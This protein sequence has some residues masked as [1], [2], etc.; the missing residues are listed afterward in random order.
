MKSWLAMTVATA[1]LGMAGTAGA[2]KLTLREVSMR[3]FSG[4]INDE[5]DHPVL[6]IDD[7]KSPKPIGPGRGAGGYAFLN[8]KLL[9]WDSGKEVGTMRGIC[10]T[11]DHGPNGPW[12][13]EVRI[14]AGGPFPSACQLS[15]EFSDGQIVGNGI[16]D[17]NAMELDKPLQMPI[18]GGTGKYRGAR[19]EVMVVQDPPGQPITYKVVLDFKTR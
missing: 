13:G 17:L 2:E 5:E 16:I 6:I 18:V 19:G 9:D 8:N 4:T 3:T 10:F 12:K 15:Y 14:G 7:L 1:A 11:I